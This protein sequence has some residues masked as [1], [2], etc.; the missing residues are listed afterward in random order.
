[1][2]CHSYVIGL[3]AGEI[4][5]AKVTSEP[6]ITELSDAISAYKDKLYTSR[7]AILCFQYLDMVELLSK[8]IQAERMGNFNLDLQ[9]V[10]EMLPYFAA[11]GHDLYTKSAYM[12]LQSCPN[13]QLPTQMCIKIFLLVIM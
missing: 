9:S 3:L 1:M 11:A 5:V 8:F 6:V 4:G 12:Y 7:T 2:N 10:K 13:L